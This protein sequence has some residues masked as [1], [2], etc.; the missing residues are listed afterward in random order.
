MEDLEA[1]RYSDALVGKAVESK[2]RVKRKTV[3]A[4]IR[5]PVPLDWIANASRIPRRNAV[6]VGSVLFYLAG[7]RDER[8]G[9]VLSVARCK[10]FGLGRKAVQRGLADLESNG[11]VRVERSAGRCPRVDILG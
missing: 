11:L 9:L 3:G 1:F 8:V 4:F 5:G 10:P 7:L 2:P 6:L